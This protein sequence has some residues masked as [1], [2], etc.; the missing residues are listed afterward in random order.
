MAHLPLSKGTHA[1]PCGRVLLGLAGLLAFAFSA[2]GEEMYTLRFKGLGVGD[3]ARVEK[4]E[5]QSTRIVAYDS[6]GRQ[7]L[8]RLEK[9]V[10]TWTY[11]EKVLEMPAGGRPTRLSRRYE[12]AQIK[13]GK[14]T[15]DLTVTGQT[16]LIEKQGDQYAFYYEGGRR[17][18]ADDAAPFDREFN[19]GDEKFR[20][21]HLLPGKPVPVGAEWR[22]DMQPLL[23]DFGR[24][25]RFAVDPV[26]S[27]GTGHLSK[28][29]PLGGAQF[30]QLL[31]RME[32]P[33]QALA[34]AGPNRQPAL[35]GA[36][37]AFE[38]TVDICID[39]TKADA[40]FLGTGKIDAV[41]PAPQPDGSAGRIVFTHKSESREV[42]K[43]VEDK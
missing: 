13:K 41:I 12:K 5:T 8:D 28:A 11:R 34:V 31:Y 38:L 27:T 9:Q 1:L 23:K 6:L 14:T 43:P 19:G 36:K 17:V 18:S 15:R 21:E 3:A 22:I 32:I 26:T 35:P 10:D 4:E 33:I 7:T 24:T 2:A 37:A 20:L 40:T 39:G 25:G 30:G 29:S 16:V 42:R